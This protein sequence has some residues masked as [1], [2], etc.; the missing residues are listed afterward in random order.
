[1]SLNIN[2]WIVNKMNLKL[3]KMTK[4]SIEI[5]ENGEKPN[6]NKALIDSYN[7]LWYHY[8]ESWDS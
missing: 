5:I 4:I 7:W 2:E 3:K 6:N 8:W 1:M